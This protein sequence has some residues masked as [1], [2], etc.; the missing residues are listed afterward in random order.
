MEFTGETS[1]F[2]S[3]RICDLRKELS[4]RGVKLSGRK[5]ELIDRLEAYERDFNFGKSQVVNQ[6]EYQMVTPKE[7]LYKDLHEGSVIPEITMDNIE[8][9]LGS[10]KKSLSRESINLVNEKFLIYIK[11]IEETVAFFFKSQCIAEMLKHVK[12]NIDIAVNSH[13]LIDKCH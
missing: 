6:S 10:L 7:H 9:Y 3:L 8:N 2:G 5:Q 4:K 13:G 1:K 11:N 12:Y